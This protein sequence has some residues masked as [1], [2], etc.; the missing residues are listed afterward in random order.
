[1]ILVFVLN[2]LV[3]VARQ[4]FYFFFVYNRNKKGL[5]AFPVSDELHSLYRQVHGRTCFYIIGAGPANCSETGEAVFFRPFCRPCMLM[6]AKVR[7]TYSCGSCRLTGIY[8]L[9]MNDHPAGGGCVV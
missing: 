6:L 1:M 4:L 2:L 3:V 8:G 5:R 7:H 9:Q